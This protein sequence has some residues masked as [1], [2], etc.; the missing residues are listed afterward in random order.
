MVRDLGAN[1]IISGRYREKIVIISSAYSKMNKVIRRRKG[2]PSPYHYG[3]EKTYSAGN[4]NHH[5]PIRADMKIITIYGT[6]LP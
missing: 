4:F 6:Q 2:P 3:P 5:I 1:V